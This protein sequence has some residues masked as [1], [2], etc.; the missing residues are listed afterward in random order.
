MLRQMEIAYDDELPTGDD[1]AAEFE[2]FL[3][4]NE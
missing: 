2:Q 4:D 1:I 3:R